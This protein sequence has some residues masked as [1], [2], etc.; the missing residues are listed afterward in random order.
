MLYAI[1]CGNVRTYAQG[2]DGL[3]YLCTTLQ[4][5]RELSLPWVATD[6]NA[7]LK[8]AE[9]VAETGRLEGLVDWQLMGATMWRSTPDDPDR[10]ERR[11]AEL[12][13]H[14]RLPWEAVQFIGTRTPGDLRAVQRLLATLGGQGH[15]VPRSDVRGRWCF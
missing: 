3:M 6:R 14:R 9:F 15:H 2:Q 11:M 12:L 10:V 13:V 7:T 8:T 5:V 1:K 4:R